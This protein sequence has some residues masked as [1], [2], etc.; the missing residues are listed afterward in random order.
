[1]RR[2]ADGAEWE[3]HRTLFG[4]SGFAAHNGPDLFLGMADADELV[5]VALTWPDGVVQMVPV[6][7]LDQRIEVRR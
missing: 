1:M 6:D 7:A 4:G 5:E 2:N 3:V